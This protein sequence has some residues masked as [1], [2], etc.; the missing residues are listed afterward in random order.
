[1]IELSREGGCQSFA[2]FGS[3]PHGN[4][5]LSGLGMGFYEGNLRRDDG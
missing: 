4:S 2:G 5:L 3:A 1:M